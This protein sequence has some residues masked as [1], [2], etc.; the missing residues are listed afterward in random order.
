MTFGA[1]LTEKSDEYVLSLVGR[2]IWSPQTLIYSLPRLQLPKSVRS[3]E[4]SV[5]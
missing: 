2:R 5:L 4:Q 1:A 3:T